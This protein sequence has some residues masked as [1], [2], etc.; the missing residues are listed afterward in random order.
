MG[1][2]FHFKHKMFLQSEM[3]PRSG[4]LQTCSVFGIIVCL[5]TQILAKTKQP[6]H[7]ATISQGTSLFCCYVLQLDHNYPIG[8][9]HHC[10]I[11]Y[12]TRMLCRL[13][14]RIISGAILQEGKRMCAFLALPQGV[15]NKK[16]YHMLS[17]LR[18]CNEELAL[19]QA[20]LNPKENI[21]CF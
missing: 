16:K 15:L 2:C 20:A 9:L 3:K 19:P 4:S 13:S 5:S 1:I 18:L 11:Y 7:T 8:H 17:R 6:G 10:V 14:C 12:S 21:T